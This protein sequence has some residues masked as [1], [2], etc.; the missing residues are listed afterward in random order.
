[1]RVDLW[2]HWLSHAMSEDC[3][4]VP[5][6]KPAE[7]HHA[8]IARAAAGLLSA[9]DPV[10]IIDGVI[11][12]VAEFL[13]VDQRVSYD[14]TED[15]AHLRLTHTNG[16]KCGELLEYA[17]LEILLAGIVAQ[18]G[19]P[20]ILHNLQDS[21]QERYALAR[22]AGVRAFAGFPIA[23][24]D[25]L[26]GVIAFAS[27]TRPLLSNEALDL[28]ATLASL[29][30]TARAR[31]EQEAAL[32]MS[33]ERLRQLNDTLEQRVQQAAAERR[34]LAAVVDNTTACVM[35][36]DPD[37]NILAVNLAQAEEFL[38][39]Y[40]RSCEA[41]DNLLQL[42]SAFPEHRERIH[43]QWKRALRG[44]R[45]LIV[46]QFGDPAYQ[47]AHYE[48]H[49][50]AMRD[51]HGKVI[52]AF[53]TAYD[54]SERVGAQR[55]LEA[56]KDALRQSQKMEAMG[57]FTGGVAHDFNNLLTP[58]MATLELLQRR[59]VGN[60]RE[61]R[62]IAGA[63][64]SA[65][66]ARVLVQR[67]LAFARRQPL[68]PVAVDAGKLINGMADLVRSTAGP[69]TKLSVQEAD[70]PTYAWADP[71]QLEM[72]LLNLC[73]NARDAMPNGGTLRISIRSQNVASDREALQAGNY[74]CISVEDSGVGMDEATLLRATEP[75]FSTKDV[76]R[77]TGLGLSMVHGL[78]AQL[79]GALQI[80]SS[81]GIGTTVYLWLPQTEP[82]D[83]VQSMASP[84]PQPEKLKLQ[85]ALVVD[86]EPLVRTTV[87][88]M[89]QELGYSVIEASCAEDATKIVERGNNI[90]LVLTDHL[91]PGMTGGELARWI[92][93]K[94]PDLPVLLISGY[95]E[96]ARLPAD[97][98]RLSKP[99][100]MSELSTRLAAMQKQLTSVST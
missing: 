94:A 23:S 35:A 81:L 6:Q 55:D 2:T 17:P 51:S 87:T 80:K 84:A 73:V 25:R 76:G 89:L 88:H 45:F 34:V 5:F 58:I 79:G 12:D 47:Q 26:Y 13:E 99:F 46:D 70:E 53:L 91:M 24:Q 36:C 32:R 65:E 43:A 71:N 92:R 22:Q 19:K 85:T 40:G 72:A 3:S 69:Q 82:Q 21:T 100:A 20:L 78:A 63:A 9:D 56:A 44:E 62:M 10:S 66:R 1:M 30:S 48:V 11:R 57:Q 4:E 18:S 98:P 15:R 27:L 96:G 83:E 64:Q 61:Q 7:Q 77:G 59:G 8:L 60:E 33:E 31:L 16:R 54:V 37:L 90:D 86:D 97:I 49:F 95:A 41:G 42:L 38:R 93:Q 29:L 52:G 50:D 68:Q 67:L 74:I 75:F 14:I 28:F 39:F